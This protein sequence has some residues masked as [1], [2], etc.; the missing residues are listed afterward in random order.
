MCIFILVVTGMCNGAT[1]SKEECHIKCVMSSHIVSVSICAICFSL[2][3]HEMTVASQAPGPSTSAVTPADTALQRSRAP[4]SQALDDEMHDD[5]L[6]SHELEDVGL[7]V[8]EDVGLPVQRQAPS[9]TPTTTTLGRRHWL[10]KLKSCVD[11]EEVLATLDELRKAMP[12]LDNAPVQS[13]RRS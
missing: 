1:L 6:L 7:P 8:G 10:T 11:A 13:A 2:A 5:R 12:R 9:V 3:V 4:L